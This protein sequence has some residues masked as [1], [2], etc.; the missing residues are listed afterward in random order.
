MNTASPARTALSGTSL[1]VA[2]KA[3]GPD[4]LAAVQ[5]LAETAVPRE[6]PQGSVVVEVHSAGVN[7]SDVKAVLGA[8]P[9]AVWPRT[10]GPDFARVVVEGPSHPW[11]ARSGALAASL[12]S[13]ATELMH[14]TSCCPRRTCGR[15]QWL[16]PRRGGGDRRALYHGL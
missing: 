5:H 16:S 3:D 9:H 1:R 2:E 14:A 15:N 6:L 10:P 4:T 12:V 8:V 13:G 11:D 7:P